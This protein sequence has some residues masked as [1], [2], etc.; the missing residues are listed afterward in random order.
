MTYSHKYIYKLL[1]KGEYNKVSSYIRNNFFDPDV[2][3]INNIDGNQEGGSPVIHLAFFEGRRDIVEWLIKN[4]DADINVLDAG[5]TSIL[6]FVVNG[7]NSRYN[8]SHLD[9]LAILNADFNNVSRSYIPYEGEENPYEILMHYGF[10]VCRLA[11]LAFME[12]AIINNN[13]HFFN[14]LFINGAIPRNLAQVFKFAL[15]SNNPQF[16]ILFLDRAP[17]DLNINLVSYN[18]VSTPL[19][20]AIDHIENVRVLIENGADVNYFSQGYAPIHLALENGNLDVVRLLLDNNANPNNINL[21]AILSSSIFATH[22]RVNNELAGFLQSLYQENNQA[23]EMIHQWLDEL[24][25]FNSLTVSPTHMVASML[26]GQNEQ[27]EEMDEVSEDEEEMD[28]ESEGEEN[29]ESENEDEAEEEEFPYDDS[30]DSEEEMDEESDNQES[31]D[32]EGNNVNE[33]NHFVVPADTSINNVA[34]NNTND[35]NN[36]ISLG[37]ALWPEFASGHFFGSPGI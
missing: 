3:P 12:R 11:N 25:N 14:F 27:A 4:H 32:N 36:N 35:E 28:Q 2:V 21:E 8:R 23:L 29:E 7:Y 5:G 1:T 22:A 31:S 16:L 9:Y 20:I 33:L 26:P 34:A 37:G 17:Q 18:Q 13:S 6:G 30:D 15:K 19:Q 10:N 24:E